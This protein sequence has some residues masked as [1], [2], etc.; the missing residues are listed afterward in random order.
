[1]PKSTSGGVSFEPGHE[2]PGVPAGE[3]VDRAVAE[4]ATATTVAPAEPAAAAEPPPASAPKADHVDHAVD[5]LGVPREEAESMTKP[6]LV[7]LARA[8]DPEPEPAK[9]R[10]KPKGAPNG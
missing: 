10:P 1:M 9:P 3:P 8:G 6:D 4:E 2:P 7:E 5:A